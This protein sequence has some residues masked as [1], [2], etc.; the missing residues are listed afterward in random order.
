MD[1]LVAKVAALAEGDAGA[2]RFPKEVAATV[3]ALTDAGARDLYVVVSLADVPERPPFA[4]L[5][6]E[7]D[8]QTAKPS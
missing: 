2:C 5:P 4:V 3:K 8:G 1:A 7:K 6:L